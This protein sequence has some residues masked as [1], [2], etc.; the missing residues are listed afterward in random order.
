M[1][2]KGRGFTIVEVSLFLAISGALILLTIGL[3]N[4]VARQRFQDTMVTLRSTIQSQ[5]EEVR[6]SINDRLAGVQVNGC[7][8]PGATDNKI[9]QSGC[10]AIG[11]LIQF[12]GP[13][14]VISYIA[15]P[16]E[17]DSSCDGR[18]DAYILTT[19]SCLSL[20][21]VKSSGSQIHTD[22][23]AIQPQTVRLQWGGEFAAGWTIPLD[24]FLSP[25][26][27]NALAILHSPS[28]SAVL[29]FAFAPYSTAS[30]PVSPS[31]GQL[32]MA[33]AK[34]NQ[35]LAMMIRNNQAGFAGAALCIGSGS[36]STAVQTVIPAPDFG[37]LVGPAVPA[38]AKLKELC[39][40]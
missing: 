39:S 32:V 13:D 12:N 30:S 5:Y 4:M 2:M 21:V 34:L 17:V 27:S 38:S 20:F 24:P 33:N 3:W 10:L 18:D 37:S 14:V 40:L 26:Q 23:P 1:V 9:G 28:S 25:L 19:S 22:D 7:D 29:V 8:A 6:T 15:S 11:K 16:G 31:K 35:P 36:S